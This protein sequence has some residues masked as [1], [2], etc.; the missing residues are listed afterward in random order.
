[1]ILMKKLFLFFLFTTFIAN[2]QEI[3]KENPFASKKNELRLDLLS[4][5]TSG[6]FGL[7]YERFLK[8]DFS[9]GINVNFSNSKNTQDDFNA[10]FR[11]NLPNHEINPYIRYALSKSKMRYYFAEIFASANGGDFKEVVRMVDS[12]NIGYYTTQKTKYS[13]FAIGGSL[14][15]KMYFKQKIALEF[16]V[17]FGKNLFN[18]NKSPD[19][20]TRVG[21][22]LGYRFQ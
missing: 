11:N 16:I 12:N 9:V 19:L 10:G 13:D 4:I 14:G 1:M 6:K 2:S 18:T 21:I 7:S 15:Y 5:I 22:N 20:V 17:G 8:N 3:S